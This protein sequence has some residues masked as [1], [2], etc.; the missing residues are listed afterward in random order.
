MDSCDQ[1]NRSTGMSQNQSH[2]EE[3]Y[4]KALVLW[5]NMGMR[6]Q[7]RQCQ[8]QISEKIHFSRMTCVVQPIKSI[9]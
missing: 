9:T 3:E 1:A 5:K 4:D 6:K 8:E 7:G 2:G